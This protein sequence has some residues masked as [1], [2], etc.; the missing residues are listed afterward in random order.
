MAES[1]EKLKSLLMKVREESEKVGLKLN[2]QKTK[3]MASS[4][5]TSWQTDGKT[6]EM[7]RD[8]I[9]LG[10]KITADG[11]FSHE[12]K[13]S[14]LLGRE[15]MINIDSIL[16]SRDITLPTKVHLVKAMVF[17]VV[18]YGCE[19][20][21]IKKAEHRII[22]AFELWYWRRLLRVPWT[23]RR[24]NQSILKEISP[25]CSLVG[26]MLKL[27][28]QYFSYLMQRTDS[29]EKTLMLGKIEGRRRMG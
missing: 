19:S 20:W 28:L 15:V 10:S 12:I 24:S 16:K 26:L 9:F 21:T 29:F 18:M 23:A 8:F 2:I 14:L 22:D 27:K 1:E 11:D 4:P 6:M 25:G 7:V 13:K 3:I 5:I 17:P